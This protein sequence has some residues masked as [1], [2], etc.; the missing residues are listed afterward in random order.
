MLRAVVIGVGLFFLGVSG[1]AE[2]AIAAL[3]TLFVSS[4]L[5]GWDQRSR[6][7]QASRPVSGGA[8][9]SPA[10]GSVRLQ[11]T[12]RVRAAPEEVWAL[13]QPAELA[14]VINPQ[15]ARGYRV[16][17]TPDGVG[18]Q[19]GF[20]DLD[21]AVTIVEVVEHVPGR[22]AVIR[23]ISPVA[24]LPAWT[25]CAVQPI[26]DGSIV[27]LATHLEPPPGVTL[28]PDWVERYS[29]DWRASAQDLL[30]RVV[31]ALP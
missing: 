8:S 5:R 12:V 21:G 4:M 6:R 17:D 16:P 11:E 22:R 28:P 23:Q 25:T 1:H 20:V 15:V 19:Q 7:R 10:A 14:P 2:A 13:I 27:A 9:A 30:A 18:E 24:A 31:R 3:V 29:N 26:D